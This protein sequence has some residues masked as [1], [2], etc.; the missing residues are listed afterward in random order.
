MTTTSKFLTLDFK[1]IGK[2]LLMAVIAP[3]LV[4]VQQALTTGEFPDWKLLGLTALSA[5]VAYVLKNLFTPAQEVRAVENIG[6]PK[7]KYP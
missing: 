5:G 3:V 6:L 7:P 4:I 2:G 1:D